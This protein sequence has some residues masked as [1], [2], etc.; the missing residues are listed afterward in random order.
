MGQ[1]GCQEGLLADS[2]VEIKE[3]EVKLLQENLQGTGAIDSY[4]IKK[5]DHVL[6]RESFQY[7]DCHNLIQKS[8]DDGNSQKIMVN[9]IL[10]QEQPFCEHQEHRHFYSL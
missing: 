8:I 4:T 9:Y 5:G 1:Q 7:D 2:F 3:E 6:I 10:R